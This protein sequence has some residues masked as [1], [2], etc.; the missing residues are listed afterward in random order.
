MMPDNLEVVNAHQRRRQNVFAAMLF[1]FSVIALDGGSARAR[2]EGCRWD[3]V[4]TLPIAVYDAGGTVAQPERALYVQGGIDR[5]GVVRDDIYRIDLGSHAVERLRTSGARASRWSHSLTWTESGGKPRLYLVGG[6]SSQEDGASA[7]K[8]IYSY[9]PGES[10]WR[11]ENFSGVS[12]SVQD[13]AAAYDPVSG[14]IIVQG[15]CPDN[16]QAG[17][18]SPQT[19]TYIIDP[20]AGQILRGQRDGPKLSGHSMVYDPSVP[21]M[22]LFGGTWDSRRGTADVYE[23][24]LDGGSPESAKWNLIE[25]SGTPPE[26]RFNH[27]AVYDVARGA[28]IL[29]GGLKYTDEPLNDT[30][31][32]DF[33]TPGLALWRDLSLLNQK[34][35][36]MVMAYDETL[37]VTLQVSGGRPLSP[38][39]S[40]D[41]FRLQCNSVPSPTPE[42]PTL[43]PVIGP[44]ET[45][46]GIQ[47]T[48]TEPSTGMPPPPTVASPTATEDLGTDVPPAVTVGPEVT[49]SQTPAATTPVGPTTEAP[50]SSPGRVWLPMIL[51]NETIR[52][53]PVP[54]SP[55]PGPNPPGSVTPA[56]PTGV[57]P[58]QVP[59][60]APDCLR[61]EAEPNDRLLQSMDWPPLCEGDWLTG[62]LPDG[63]SGDYYRFL[64]AA[65]G[66]YR[67]ELE[68]IP[69]GR[70]YDLLL[71][72]FAGQLVSSSQLPGNLKETI[73]IG[74]AA[75]QYVLRVYPSTGRSEQMYRL[76]WAR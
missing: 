33:S 69:S 56:R 17:V 51:R 25:T 59:T 11:I 13:H 73:T 22:L 66:E 10:T 18:C 46:P 36:G 43:P 41:I 23:L 49:P 74:L 48:A 15:G 30:W 68:D 32:L 29:Y 37:H 70:D 71:Y 27:G 60:A 38:E 1:V 24:R 64:V 12:P 9:D 63:D 65:S 19:E 57:A 2:I 52:S 50:T 7:E 72:D 26:R 39:A 44:S 42:S 6:N 62:S 54:Q 5:D 45:P 20:S 40:K 58:T 47:P 16:G 21:R 34:R 75:E 61:V 3:Q 31:A 55:T 35:S 28:M 76:R 67:I 53:R 8:R 14:T 4:Q